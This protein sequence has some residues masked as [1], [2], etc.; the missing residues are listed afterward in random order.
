[1]VSS[2]IILTSLYTSGSVHLNKRKS[3]KI[4][5]I[6]VSK[7][8]FLKIIEGVVIVVTASYSTFHNIVIIE[9]YCITEQL[10]I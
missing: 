10:T 3:K 4:Q 7:P 2:P 9:C 6:T 8:K 1:M 5:S